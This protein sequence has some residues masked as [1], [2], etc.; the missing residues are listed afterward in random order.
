M[1]GRCRVV[2]AVEACS[3]PVEDISHTTAGGYT[4]T[5]LLSLRCTLNRLSDVQG[6]PVRDVSV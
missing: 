5:K 1:T 4:P 6:I 3:K 2:S